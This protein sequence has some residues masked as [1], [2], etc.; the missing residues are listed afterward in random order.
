MQVF[1]AVVLNAVPLGE[2]ALKNFRVLLRPGAGYKKV[3]LAPALFNSS[4]IAGIYSSPQSTFMVMAT[5]FCP[6][7][8]W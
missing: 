6:L 1:I 2:Y 7:F 8:P 3:A 4:S 5:A